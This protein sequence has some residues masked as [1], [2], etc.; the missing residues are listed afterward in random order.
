MSLTSTDL[1]SAKPEDLL[2][3]FARIVDELLS[4]GVVRSTNNP[5]ADY[6]EYLTARALGLTL[7]ANSSIGFDAIGEDDVRYQVKARRLTASNGSRQLGFIRGLETDED[8]FDVLVGILFNA[9]FTVLRAA[10][11]PIEVVRARVARIDYVNAWRLVL[12]DAVWSVPGVED[13]TDRIRAAAAAPA[14]APALVQAAPPRTKAQA[15]DPLW[16]TALRRYAAPRTLRTRA[17]GS[18]FEVAAHDGWL[19]ITPGTGR[20]RRVFEAEFVAAIPL[21]GAASRQDL[22]S[23]T[24]NSSYLGA[25]VADLKGGG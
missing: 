19:A 25:I 24:F 13:V 6:S 16:A 12:T 20:A 15:S 11:V 2:A 23:V 4:Q 22:H 3:L 9:D 1:R 10:M 5:V 8:P 14:A 21:I 7:V 17:R 18:E